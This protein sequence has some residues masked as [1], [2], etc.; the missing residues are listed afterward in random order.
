MD[1]IEQLWLSFVQYLE[2]SRIHVDI[3]RK[4]IAAAMA[5]A[6]PNYHQLGT[7]ELIYHLNLERTLGN[8]RASYIPQSKIKTA[9]HYFSASESTEIEKEQ[10]NNYCKVPINI[11]EI[12]GDHF[13]IFKIPN[14]L[15][16]TKIFDILISRSLELKE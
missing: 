7:R 14:V 2:T 5:Q 1:N 16:L 4:M 9:L 6:I 8:A 11:Y 12:P 3:V 13:S 10:W 15:N